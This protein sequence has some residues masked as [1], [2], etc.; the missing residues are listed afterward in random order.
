MASKLRSSAPMLV[1]LLALGIAVG[2]GSLVANASASAV[3]LIT[4]KDVQNSS[5]TGKDVKDSSL[6][7]ADMKNGSLLSIDFKSGQLPTGAQG[8]KGDKGDK[9]DPG[10]PGSPAQIIGTD[11]TGSISGPAGLV[12]AQ[13]CL[14]S[15]VTVAGALVGDVPLLAFVGNVGAPAGLTFQVLKITASDQGILRYCNPSNTASPA[16]TNVGVRIITLR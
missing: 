14:T 7:T 4:G 6:T 13:S 15:S 1:A 3:H 16:F 2:G 12:A 9:G 11:I 10:A 5:L 8:P